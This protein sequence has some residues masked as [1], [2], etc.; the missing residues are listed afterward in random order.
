MIYYDT[1]REANIIFYLCTL[2][3]GLII[4]IL[5]F[6]LKTWCKRK[7]YRPE[8]FGDDDRGCMVI[9]TGVTNCELLVQYYKLYEMKFDEI[10]KLLDKEIGNDN[11]FK[12]A[13]RTAESIFKVQ[14]L[15]YE[16]KI[17]KN[18]SVLGQQ[19]YSYLHYIA[20]ICYTLDNP[21]FYLTFNTKCRNTSVDTWCDFPY[22]S[23]WYLLSHIPIDT[24]SQVNNTKNL[25]AFV[26]N[27]FTK[28]PRIGKFFYSK[29][30]QAFRG[31]RFH[32]GDELQT[33]AV[34]I[35][36]QFTSASLRKEIALCYIT[37]SQA[38]I[39]TLIKF[40]L[41]P[42]ASKSIKQYSLFPQEEEI[43]V[44]PWS[45]FV[46]HEINRNGSIHNLVLKPDH[47]YDDLPTVYE[48]KEG[49]TLVGSYHVNGLQF[50]PTNPNEVRI[51]S[52]GSHSFSVRALNGPVIVRI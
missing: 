14:E 51:D 37:K 35:L 9:N 52:P 23:L 1:L 34:I 21:R 49:V 39:G 19:S 31:V 25:V 36:K 8:R 26:V 7:N 50:S 5:I 42:C 41:P 17:K 16:K 3:V 32:Y 44:Y 28:I 38:K 45:L 12:N 33:K 46:V 43:L 24:L 18:L 13:W 11:D 2:C 15:K 48:K 29:P 47:R 27:Y 30:F 6:E 40:L 20:L 4:I 10:I 22:K